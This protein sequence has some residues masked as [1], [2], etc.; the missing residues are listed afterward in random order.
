LRPVRPTSTL[1][2]AREVRANDCLKSR[3]IHL[4]AAEGRGCLLRC[5]YWTARETAYQLWPLQQEFYDQALGRV[6]HRE[7]FHI[8]REYCEGVG[9]GATTTKGKGRSLPYHIY[10]AA[11]SGIGAKRPARRR[12]E[13][14]LVLLPLLGHASY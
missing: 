6:G 11:K 9:S 14:V 2:Q 3:E 10:G 8:R 12:D 7:R 13:R 4:R 1:E 5:Q